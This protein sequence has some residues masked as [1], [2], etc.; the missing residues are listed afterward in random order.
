MITT[1]PPIDP[2]VVAYL[3][4]ETLDWPALDRARLESV[5]PLLA[6]RLAGPD[7]HEVVERLAPFQ[8]WEARRLI[9]A[10]DDVAR[11]VAGV[12]QEAHQGHNCPQLVALLGRKLFECERL[13]V[14]LMLESALR[15][16]GVPH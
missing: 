2:E 13:E 10:L 1:S 9:D 6:A 5:L 12:C 8:P 3:D 4:H 14:E 16:T 15:D 11:C 7:P